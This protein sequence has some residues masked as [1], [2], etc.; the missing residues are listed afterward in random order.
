MKNTILKLFVLFMLS[1]PAF[2][3][4]HITPVE[5]E[6]EILSYANSSVEVGGLGLSGAKVQEFLGKV[7]SLDDPSGYLACHRVAFRFAMRSNLEDGLDWDYKRSMRFAEKVA[8]KENKYDYIVT[9]QSAYVVVRHLLKYDSLGQRT[10]AV[11]F[12]HRFVEMPK[13]M[14]GLFVFVDAYLDYRV[15]NPSEVDLAHDYAD[16]KLLEWQQSN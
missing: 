14:D 10:Y 6:N 16:E 1:L 4:V 9:F 7:M 13:G 12:S 15:A 5:L 11:E 2:A 8:L 3:K